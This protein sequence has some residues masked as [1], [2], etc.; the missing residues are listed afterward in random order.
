M[1]KR[2]EALQPIHQSLKKG[3]PSRIPTMDRIQLK[4]EEN[5]LFQRQALDIFTHCSNAGLSFHDTLLAII[6]TGFQWGVSASKGEL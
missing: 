3:L 2:R 5:E 6:L 4:Q 1:T